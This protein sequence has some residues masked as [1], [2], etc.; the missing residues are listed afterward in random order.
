MRNSIIGVVVGVVLSIAAFAIVGVRLDQTPQVERIWPLALGLVAA[1]I[2]WVLQGLVMY[3]LAKP[4]LKSARLSDM[5]GIY[6]AAAFIGG[7]SPVRGLEIPYE[8]YLLKRVGLPIGMGGAVVITRGLLNSTVV[9]LG[10][11]VGL[12][13]FSG[14]LEVGNLTFLG[15]ALLLAAVWALITFIARRSRGQSKRESGSGWKVRVFNYLRELRDGFGK[16]WRSSPR[17][18]VISG[19]I[20]ILYWIVRLSIGPLALLTAGANSDSWLAVIIA[21][22]VLISFVLSLAPTPGASGAAELGFVSFVS[23]Y[24]ATGV[25]SGALIWR[26]LTHFLQT[27]I[28]AYFVGRQTAI[29]REPEEQSQEDG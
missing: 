27:I 17:I 14:R 21:Q 25:L 7:I 9:V 23:P 11:I 24:V 1:V 22:T 20:M 28:G 19:L 12:V 15:I 26:V 10:A 4:H 6:L 3:L 2:T 18:L 29:S 13:F 5:V 16:I 8:V